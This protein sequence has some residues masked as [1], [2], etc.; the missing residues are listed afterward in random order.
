MP[1][2]HDFDEL[3]A[4]LRIDRDALDEELLHQPHDFFH[5]AEA[6]AMAKSRRDKAK[7]DLEVEIATLDKDVRDTMISND[8]KVTETTVKMQITREDDFHQAQ[9]V[10]LKACF[11]A[12]KWDALQ[13]AFRQRADALRSLVQ[14]HNAG[15]FGEITGASERKEAQGRFDRNRRE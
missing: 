3:A 10:Y 2:E 7:H 8:E 6:H 5:V 1:R 13:N 9:K 11:E 12:D 15:Y 14:L 4:R